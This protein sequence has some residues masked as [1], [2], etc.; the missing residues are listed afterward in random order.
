MRG[1]AGRARRDD[2][3]PRKGACAR[4]HKG[5]RAAK[6]GAGVAR[7]NGGAP[8]SPRPQVVKLANDKESAKHLAKAETNTDKLEKNQARARA[9][10]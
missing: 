10:G 2:A 8:A 5:A 7:A 1:A 9:G 3:L 4:A 6:F